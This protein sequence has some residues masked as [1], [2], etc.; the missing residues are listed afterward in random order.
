M[1]TISKINSRKK[2]VSFLLLS[3][4]WPTTE[5]QVFHPPFLSLVSFNWDVLSH[6]LAELLLDERRRKKN[7][8][9]ISPVVVSDGVAPRQFLFTQTFVLFLWGKQIQKLWWLNEFIFK[10]RNYW[11]HH[12][13][14]ATRR[15]HSQG[16]S[17]SLVDVH[18]STNLSLHRKWK[19]MKVVC[20]S[21]WWKHKEETHNYV[22]PLI[23]N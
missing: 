13:V 6:W 5:H 9:Q 19:Q 14:Q 4:V 11:M 18:H 22:F 23:F 3:G 10:F 12:S 17:Y 2:W 1:K 16:T 8:S 20:S 15:Q 7:N 21:L